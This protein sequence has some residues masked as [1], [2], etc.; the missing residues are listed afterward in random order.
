MAGIC[1][2]HTHSHY[3][4]GTCAPA[5]LIREAECLGLTALALTDHNTVDGLPEFLA[6]AGKSS[7]E[8]IPGVE[9]STG[10]QGRELHILGLYLPMDRLE[11]IRSFLQIIHI[12]KEQSNR[13]LVRRLQ[14]AGYDIDYDAIRAAHPQG[15]V[16]RAV[17]AGVLQEKGYVA[18]IREAFDTL[19]SR[20]GPYFIPPERVDAF[21]A[22]E[23]LKGLGAV[24]VLA[25]PCL[26]L[27]EEALRRFLPEAKRHGLQAMETHYSGYTPE[28]TA[29][30]RTLVRELELLESGGS[31]YHGSIKPEIRLGTGT[32]DL[33]VSAALA[34]RLKERRGL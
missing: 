21:Q 17:I 6:A 12:R 4:D 27:T 19:L 29:I 9:I 31:D 30:A 23:F 11:E 20:K 1:D 28:M 14:A 5:A 8:A 24:S 10:W 33:R 26:D 2:L 13:D 32:G 7:L 25:H 16:N 18:Q 22:L 3:S 15:T 34:A